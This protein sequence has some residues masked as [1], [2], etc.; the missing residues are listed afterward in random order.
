M[1]ASKSTHWRVSSYSS[2]ASS[3]L[4]SGLAQPV[5]GHRLVGPFDACA[6]LVD[7]AHLRQVEHQLAVPHQLLQL[8]LLG[9][10]ARDVGQ[11]GHGLG[12][13]PAGWARRTESE[14]QRNWSSVPARAT[15][16]RKAGPGPARPGI[17]HT[18]Q[19]ADAAAEDLLQGRSRR[20][21]GLEAQHALETQVAAHQQRAAQIGDAGGGTVQDGRQ[22]AQQLFVAA[23]RAFLFRHVQRDDRGRGA[24]ASQ[25]AG[26]H[27]GQQPAGP[28]L[29]VAHGITHFGALA[30]A[31]RLL[32]ALELGQRSRLDQFAPDAQQGPATSGLVPTPLGRAACLREARGGASQPRVGVVGG[33]TDAGRVHQHAHLELGQIAFVLGTAVLHH[34]HHAAGPVGTGLAGQARPQPTRPAIGHRHQGL[35]FDGPRTGNQRCGQRAIFPGQQPLQRRRG[36]LQHFGHT[37]H[38]RLEGCVATQDQAGLVIDQHAAD[39]QLEPLRQFVFGALRLLARIVFG[40]LVVPQRQP[41]GPRAGPGQIDQGDLEPALTALGVE[42]ATAQRV[43]GVRVLRALSALFVAE[44]AVVGG[45]RSIGSRPTRAERDWPTSAA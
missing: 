25:G 45:C 41:Q 26:L 35:A 28:Q 36:I 21:A 3:V 9:L 32:Q 42:Q 38:Q 39:A 37:L 20:S 33:H 1:R 6:A 7:D 34:G 18:V 29:R 16:P 15:R 40:R 30:L 14:Y 13:R 24:A 4:S 8:G 12:L 11:H 19:R 31:Q 27:T 2:A 5:S 22:L 43:L 10:Q 23:L 44:C 17:A